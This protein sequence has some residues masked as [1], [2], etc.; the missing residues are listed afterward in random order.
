MTELLNERKRLLINTVKSHISSARH[1]SN[2]A[3]ALGYVHSVDIYFESLVSLQ[4]HI[5]D[6][7]SQQ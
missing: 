7:K 5:K 6:R 3:K 1:E 2:L 4:D